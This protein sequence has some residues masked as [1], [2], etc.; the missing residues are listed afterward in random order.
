MRIK[1][2]SRT[3]KTLHNGIVAM[4]MYVLNLVLQFVSRGVFLH[5]LGTEILGLNTTASNILQFLNLAELGVWSAVAS[6]LYKPLH[7]HDEETICRI[8][9]FNGALYRRIG[10]TVITGALAVMGFFPLIFAK[11]ELP[12]YYAYLSFGVLLFSS[13]LGY[14]VNY[15]QFI[16]SADQKNYKVQYT[17]RLA[18]SI[19]LLTQIAAM[20]TLPHPFFTWLSLEVVFAVVGSV[21]LER[22]VKRTYP[23]LKD[24]GESFK[25]L[26]QDYPEIITKTKQLFIQKISGYVLFQTSPFIIYGF[27][28]LTL[29]TL[30]G[31]YMLIVNGMISLMAAVFNGMLAGIGNLV[32]SSTRRHVIDV[33]YQ[34]FSL[35]FLIITILTFAI[36]ACGQSF[37]EI[38]IGQKYLL[39]LSTLAI[40]AVTFWVYVNRYVIYD[41]LSAYGYFGDIWAS[42]AEVVVNIA[43]SIVLGYF[44]GLNGILSGV[45][46]S[47]IIISAIWKPIYLFRIKLNESLRRF[48]SETSLMTMASLIAACPCM[49]LMHFLSSEVESAIQRFATGLA[50]TVLYGIALTIV[51][52]FSFPSFRDAIKRFKA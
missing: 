9:T 3:G 19:K 1:A 23:F 44:F 36:I 32:A 15:R 16:L 45:L 51:F 24:T 11:M 40:L 31:N 12:L 35:R 33:F 50:T 22:V 25:S 4:G 30:Y 39:P 2:D 41:Y 27:A 49:A 13:L 46:I 14:F 42:I 6:S 48:W 17:L 34:L 29:V 47:L 5:Y 26:R 37:V 38:W 20:L 18:Q 10:L 8:S 21:A 28:S 7:E 43:F 52:Y